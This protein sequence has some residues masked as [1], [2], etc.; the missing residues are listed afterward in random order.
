MNATRRQ[1]YDD[2]RRNERECAYLVQ[3]PLTPGMGTTHK[4]EMAIIDW[5]K[6]R[7]LES[8]RGRGDAVWC[9]KEERDAEDFKAAFGGVRVAPRYTRRGASRA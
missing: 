7:L 9:F 4:T 2:P 3:I 6:A 1:L 8:R 5:H